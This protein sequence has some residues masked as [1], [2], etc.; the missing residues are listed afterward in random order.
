MMPITY[1]IE[2]AMQASGL[3][4]CKIYELLGQGKIEARKDGRRTL[5]PAESLRAYLSSLPAASI[6]AQK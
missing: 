2:G 6:S 5:I 3:P 4:R 1:S